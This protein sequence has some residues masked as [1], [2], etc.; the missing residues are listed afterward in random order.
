MTR[1]KLST[2][3]EQVVNA[4]LERGACLTE[5]SK[6]GFEGGITGFIYHG[7]MNE[8]FR[9][10][11]VEMLDAVIDLDEYAYRDA[12]HSA[13]SSIHAPV[14]AIVWAMIEVIATNVECKCD[15]CTNADEDNEDEE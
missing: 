7:V 2:Q 10:Y 13:A 14:D 1:Q 12:M 9:A 5:I 3:L 15:K 4:V 8:F 11:G 6:Y